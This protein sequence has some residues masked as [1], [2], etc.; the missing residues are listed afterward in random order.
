MFKRGNDVSLG[1]SE[2][3]ENSP[4]WANYSDLSEQAPPLSLLVETQAHPQ[5]DEVFSSSGMDKGA[6]HSSAA[7]LIPPGPEVSK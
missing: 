7:E 6:S 3:P 2:V 1:E 5:A 4:L